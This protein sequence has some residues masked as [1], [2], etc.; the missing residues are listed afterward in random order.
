MQV[1]KTLPAF[2]IKKFKITATFLK[3]FLSVL[4][5]RRILSNFIWQKL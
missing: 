4:I 3:K 2:F 1:E 5:S